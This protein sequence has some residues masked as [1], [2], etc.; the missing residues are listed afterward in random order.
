MNYTIHK[1]GWTAMVDLD[2]KLAT[3]NDINQ[4]AKLVATNTCVVFRNQELSVDDEVRICKMFKNPRQFYPE[5]V[6]DDS[7]YAGTIIPNSDDMIIRVTPELDEH[8][9][10]G[11]SGD[12]NE[13]DWHCNDPTREERH[14]IV[15]LYSVRGSL[16]S[17]TT[18]N[19]NIY[20]Y[21]SLDKATKDKLQPLKLAIK[22]FNTDDELTRHA[23]NLVHTNIAGEIGLFFPFLQMTRFKGMTEEESK[24]IMDPLI[25]HT[26]QE[27][28]L[29]HH[30]WQDGDVIISEQWL[31]IHKRWAFDGIGNRLLHRVVFDFPDQDYLK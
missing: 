10:H 24:V 1:N 14:P 29:Y 6:E 18:W 9:R 31:G 12:C 27:E 4:I 28:Y 8:G 17:R 22:H 11:L 20:S 30:D 19:N 16:G 5:T 2:L 26:T 13:L 3:Q 21:N 7:G 15:W 23:P 25:K